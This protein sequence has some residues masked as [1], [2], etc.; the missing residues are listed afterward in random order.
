MNHATAAVRIHDPSSQAE[1]EPKK[2]C[3][4]RGRE[5]ETKDPDGQGTVGACIGLWA[6]VAANQMAGEIMG[7]GSAGLYSSVLTRVGSQNVGELPDKLRA[8]SFP[9]ENQIQTVPRS[10]ELL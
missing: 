6:V 4:P 8:P 9:A 7:G 10:R 2:R 1:G 3:I 5:G